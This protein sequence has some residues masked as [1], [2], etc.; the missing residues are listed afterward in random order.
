MYN[1]QF[2]LCHF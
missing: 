2:V 1:I